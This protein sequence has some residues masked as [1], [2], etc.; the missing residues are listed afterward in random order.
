VQIGVCDAG[1]CCAISVLDLDS[2]R[3]MLLHMGFTS[4][5]I[6]LNLVSFSVKEPFD[7]CRVHVQWQV[8]CPPFLPKFDH[9]NNIW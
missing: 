5:S 8:S 4:V 2:I 9:P 3:V 1:I 6:K 7:M